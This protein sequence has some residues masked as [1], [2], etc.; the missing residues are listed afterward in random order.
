[1]LRFY[2]AAVPKGGVPIGIM[3]AIPW[4]WVLAAFVASMA[5]S[6]YMV[7]LLGTLQAAARQPPSSVDE[8]CPQKKGGKKKKRKW[9]ACSPL[10]RLRHLATT[11]RTPTLQ[12]TD[13][14]LSFSPDCDFS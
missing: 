7:S 9:R 10:A 12:K 14:L 6:I 4:R 5:M 11:P 1:M 3:G 2:A 13:C 8:D